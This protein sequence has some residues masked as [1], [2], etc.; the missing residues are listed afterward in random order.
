MLWRRLSKPMMAKKHVTWEESRGL[1]KMAIVLHTTSPVPCIEWKLP[2]AKKKRKKKEK[3]KKMTFVRS[4]Q[5]MLIGSGKV[6]S[7]TRR[8]NFT[9]TNDVH[10][11]FKPY[12]ATK[13]QGVNRFL[14]SPRNKN[15][16]CYQWA[17]IIQINVC[18]VISKIDRGGCVSNLHG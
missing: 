17:P 10:K 1:D 8:Q 9:W 11:S 14:I 4:L 6:L 16:P 5:T 7:P 3:R 15:N 12:G 18:R 13:L 2:Y